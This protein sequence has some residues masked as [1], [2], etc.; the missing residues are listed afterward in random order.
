MAI[1]PQH[2]SIGR[3]FE[4]HFTF[5]VPKYQRNY[6]WDETELSDFWDD[7]EKCFI[8]RQNG[9]PKHHFFG[10]VVSIK[11]EISGSA[12]QLFDLIDG[13]QRMATFILFMSALISE[14]KATAEEADN[15]NDTANKDLAESRVDRLVKLYIK[16]EDEINRE[17]IEVDRLELSLP[18]KQFFKDIVNDNSPAADRDSHKRVKYAYDL[19][20]KKIHEILESQTTITDKLDCLDRFHQIVLQ[21]CTIIHIVTDTKDEAYRLFQVL[22]DRGTCL[23]EGDL[24][25]ART[26]ELL[27][28]D[29]HADKQ[30]SVLN[31]W[32][33]ILADHP[34]D[35][36]KFLRW[37]F[38]SVK[39]K[40]PSK[41][42]LFDD[43]L[44]AFFPQ[45]TK[46]VA[47]ITEA[48]ATS[49]LNSV[50]LLEKEVL[51][52]RKL[53]EGEW[54]YES[55]VQSPAWNK[56]RL[57]LL[58]VDLK[59]THSMPFILAACKLDHQKFSQLVHLVERFFFR[60][61]VICNAHIGPLTK[62]YLE[63]AQ[64]I[65]ANPSN[66][67]VSS[68]ANK[69]RTLQNSK[70]RDNLFRS[71]LPR[72]L[73]YSKNKSN[74]VLKYFLMTAEHYYRWYL[75]GHN[76][77]PTCMDPTR[78]F[79]Y[80][81]TTIEH[82]YPQNASGTGVDAALEPVKHTLGN[83]SFLGPGDNNLVGNDDFATK[84]PTLEQSS[85]LMN[86]KIAEKT[87]W[88]LATVNARTTELI[89]LALNVFKG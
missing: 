47:D 71:E 67:N 43:F 4:N 24:L 88:D 74:K 89:D 60:Y 62:I 9:S 6:A 19:M 86:N 61:K 52:M 26:L 72:E 55:T 63:E 45:H 87:T 85:V 84:Q 27:D 1:T 53:I 16:F 15:A 65:R 79:D 37:Y 77:N 66:Y 31:C 38:A 49:I 14:T 33:K 2:I 80:A 20:Q 10:G 12:R 70:A 3:L 82:I 42:D 51:T 58:I 25:K 8:A 21:D 73:V 40:R 23:T 83:L 78:L 44:K 11:Q 28:S 13:Q 29:T 22:N 32:N 41:T 46:E 7:I 48:D 75:D 50:K 54:P 34:D 5:Q 81:N 68:F 39:G 18:D 69:V 56:E 57:R 36:E 35:T 30:D 17:L 64:L 59:H 76:G